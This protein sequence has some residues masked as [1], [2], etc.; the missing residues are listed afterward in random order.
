M[1]QMKKNPINHK[2]VE[3]ES[4]NL[5]RIL[6]AMVY[7]TLLLAAISIAYGA[8]VVVLRVII[9]GAP[10]SGQRIEWGLALGCLISMGWLLLLMSFYIYFWRKFGQTLGMKTWRFQLVDETT[11]QLAST[12]KCV[13]RSVCA[14]FSIAFFGVGYWCK[15]FHPKQRT[16]HD[17]VSGTKH[18]LL[19]KTKTQMQ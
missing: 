18:I 15:F 14:I 16:L 2:P 7:D 9:V 1:S 12:S 5:A 8:C 4:P 3:Y 6:A 11:N 17:L 13:A 19:K 10:E